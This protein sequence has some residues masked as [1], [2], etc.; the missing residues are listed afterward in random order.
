MQAD[1]DAHIAKLFG[2]NAA[3]TYWKIYEAL[4]DIT[5]TAGL[6]DSGGSHRYGVAAVALPESFDLR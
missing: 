2:A 6:D 5:G 3:K 1:L 4:R